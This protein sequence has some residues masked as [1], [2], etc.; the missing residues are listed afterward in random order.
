MDIQGRVYRIAVTMVAGF[1]ATR[2][3][4]ALWRFAM[5][6]DPPHDPEDLATPSTSAVAF[7]GLAAGTAAVAHTMATR[8]AKRRKAARSA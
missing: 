1:V 4:N 7:A 6:T 2:L 3:L 5:K 8:H